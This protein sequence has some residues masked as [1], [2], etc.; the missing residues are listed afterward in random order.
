MVQ[1]AVA[2]K[3]AP[4]G[5]AEPGRHA[6]EAEAAPAI[7]TPAFL[8]GAARMAGGVSSGSYMS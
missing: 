4:G 2:Y 6:S 7:G 3:P 5:K 8:G 1:A